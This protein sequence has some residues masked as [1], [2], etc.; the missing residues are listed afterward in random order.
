MFSFSCFVK[1]TPERVSAVSPLIGS[2]R[3]LPSCVALVS[4]EPN[5]AAARSRAAIVAR[6]K[7]PPVSSALVASCLKVR[8]FDCVSFIVSA[9]IARFSSLASANSISRLVTNSVCAPNSPIDCATWPRRLSAWRTSSAALTASD[10]NLAIAIPAPTTAADTAAKAKPIPFPRLPS[11]C[12]ACLTPVS[13]NTDFSVTFTF[14]A[15]RT[16][17]L[18]CG[19]SYP[20]LPFQAA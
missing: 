14:P 16:F 13:S 2:C 17:C 19:S 1:V 3:A 18:A 20:K 12:C 4:A 15:I 9:S 10:P 6:S 5:P 11:S 7:A 8:S